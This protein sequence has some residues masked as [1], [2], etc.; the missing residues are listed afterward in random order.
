MAMYFGNRTCKFGM[1]IVIAFFGS[2]LRAQD[3]LSGVY[4]SVKD[5]ENGK[6]SY[7]RPC[8]GKRHIRL[9]EFLAKPYITLELKDRVIR[10]FKD[11]IY[12]VEVCDGYPRRFYRRYDSNYMLVESGSITIYQKEE[13]VPY[14]KGYRIASRFFF[15]VTPDGEIMPLTLENLKNIYFANHALCE[16]LDRTFENGH[17]AAYDPENQAFRVNAFLDRYTTK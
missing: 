9:H 16:A 14:G 17:L 13:N 6:L 15:S 10:L 7:A 3:F 4:L 11:S 8:D 1:L 12:G 2:R 5:F